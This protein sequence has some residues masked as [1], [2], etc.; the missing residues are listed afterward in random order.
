MKRTAFIVFLL[1]A[2]GQL[3]PARA[4]TLPDLHNQA[5]WKEKDKQD[6]LKFLKSDQQAPVTGQVKNVAAENSGSGVARRARYLTL[7]MFSDSLM[8]TG[9]NGATRTSP[10]TF[11]PQL[12]AGG[13][14]FSWIR[15]Y[16]GFKYN[17]VSQDM[18]N[19]K[20]ARLEHY[21]IPVGIELALI[22]L[23][24]PQTRYVLMRAGIS[25]HRFTGRAKNSDF[26]TS[27]LGWRSAWNVAVGYEWQIPETRWRAHLLADGYRS[28]GNSPKFFGAGLSGGFAYTF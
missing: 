25:E 7:D 21:E 10:L 1:L 11:G 15:Y 12:T 2:S 4:Q 18:L 13:H 5:A 3:I 24:T 19:G 6:F 20:R 14:L 8:V 28:F 17:H 23:G 27:V 26:D 9:S 16:A 22:P